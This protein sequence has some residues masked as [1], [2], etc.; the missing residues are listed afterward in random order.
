MS[1][2]GMVASVLTQVNMSGLTHD[3]ER[4]FSELE[5]ADSLSAEWMDRSNMVRIVVSK[6]TPTESNGAFQARHEALVESQLSMYP[7]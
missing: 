7:K 2:I 5:E 6:R 1:L 3:I 4:A